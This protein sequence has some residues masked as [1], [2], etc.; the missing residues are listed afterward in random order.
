MLD[1]VGVA[2]QSSHLRSWFNLHVWLQAEQGQ[3]LKALACYVT[4][5]WRLPWIYK[6]H[7][8][9]MGAM[10]VFCNCIGFGRLLYNPEMSLQNF[11]AVSKV[12]ATYCILPRSCNLIVRFQQSCRIDNTVCKQAIPKSHRLDEFTIKI[13]LAC[14]VHARLQLIADSDWHAYS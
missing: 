13:C 12:T 5:W 7:H 14:N 9:K 10:T 2:F 4:W 3:R 1:Q 6:P 11:H 8:S